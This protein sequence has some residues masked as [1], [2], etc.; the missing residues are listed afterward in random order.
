MLN[1]CTETQQRQGIQSTA[2]VSYVS[3]VYSSKFLE[4]ILFSEKV[5]RNRESRTMKKHV[6][7]PNSRAYIRIVKRN[8]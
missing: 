3:Y 1:V 2:Y 4:V 6:E 8:P 5:C 7:N